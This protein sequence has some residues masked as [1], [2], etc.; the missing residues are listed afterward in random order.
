[1]AK[2]A[3]PDVLEGIE[4][5]RRSTVRN[6]LETLRD[7]S[8]LHNPT[9]EQ[10]L[11]AAAR[12]GVSRSRFYRIHRAWRVNGDGVAI[13]IADRGRRRGAANKARMPDKETVSGIMRDVILSMANVSPIAEVTKEVRVRCAAAGVRPPSQATVHSDIML[14]RSELAVPIAEPAHIAF[15]RC[16]LR[17][18]VRDGGDV[19]LPE[20]LIAMMLPQ[21]RI[22]SIAV[23]FDGAPRV[24]DLSGMDKAGL[25]G[26]RRVS[27]NDY[28][29]AAVDNLLGGKTE[30]IGVS[31]QTMLS[32]AVGI[33]IGGVEILYRQGTRSPTQKM[34][35]PHEAALNPE[36]A[37]E[38]ISKAVRTHNARAAA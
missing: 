37:L 8:R 30:H 17:L 33:A 12:Y 3:A 9:G 13:G 4:P 7:Y 20:V 14:A 25:E 18:P 38:A 11:A 35:S 23:S 26:G 19:A 29:A 27:V 28:D 21:R 5:L 22:L 36:E 2:T 32:R 24:D 10:T 15:A 1:M 34:R 31:P 6:R 16:W